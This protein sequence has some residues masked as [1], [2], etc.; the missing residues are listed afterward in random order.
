[1]Y[2]ESGILYV[3]ASLKPFAREIRALGGVKEFLANYFEYEELFAPYFT[4][5]RPFWE[6]RQS[7]QGETNSGALGKKLAEYPCA[8]LSHHPSHRFVGFGARVANA[9]QHHD[10]TTSCFHPIIE[11]AQRFDFSMLLLGCV[12]E[13]PGFSTVHATQHLLGLS[14]K[15]LFRYLIRWDIEAVE[16]IRSMTARESPGCSLSF[17]KFYPEYQKDSNL[18]QGELL[19][20]QFLFVKS[21]SRALAI[22]RKV[23]SS[24]PRFV[25][26]G[27][28]ACSTCRFRLY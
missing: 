11:L 13:S 19:G 18:F 15:H 28:L 10:H 9:L 17:G 22:E 7:G 20:K 4:R 6:K 21:A 25:D 5:A 27:R 2:S 3:R 14:Q 12:D 8:V 26:C 1:M 16:G 24:N 23:L